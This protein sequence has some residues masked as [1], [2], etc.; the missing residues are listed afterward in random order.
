MDVD[1][2]LDTSLSQ[3]DD[4]SNQ[5]FDNS[6]G[7]VSFEYYDPTLEEES[8]LAIKQFAIGK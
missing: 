5:D 8:L 1:I 3:D 6:T 2:D 7:E 4:Y